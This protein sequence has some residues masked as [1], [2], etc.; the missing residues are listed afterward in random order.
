MQAA[1]VAP[2]DKGYPPCYSFLR[3]ELAPL[4]RAAE[5]EVLD[6]ESASLPLWIWEYV[7]V[8]NQQKGD[9]IIMGRGLG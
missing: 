9:L 8:Q 4:Y 2:E 1:L 5:L 6:S 3:K 7:E